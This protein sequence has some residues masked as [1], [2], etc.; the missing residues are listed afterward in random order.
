MAYSL[1]RQRHPE[2][3]VGNCKRDASERIRQSNNEPSQLR[4][5]VCECHASS[6]LLAGL[7]G[8]AECPE[9]NPEQGQVLDEGLP[10]NAE[11][12]GKPPALDARTPGVVTRKL[13]VV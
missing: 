6:P 8:F 12:A 3:D 13:R 2:A 5:D 9:R 10:R 1:H 7:P 11:R 4:F